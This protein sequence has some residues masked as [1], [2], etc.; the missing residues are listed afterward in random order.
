MT[1]T[2]RL[3][4]TLRCY[5]FPFFGHYKLT[6]YLVHLGRY[7]SSHAHNTLP[8]HPGTRVQQRQGTTEP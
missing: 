7:L 6:L 3:L 1:A 2:R 5:S 4:L 8:V